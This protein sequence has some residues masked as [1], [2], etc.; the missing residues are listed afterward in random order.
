M[1]KVGKRLP[2]RRQQTIRREM[3]AVRAANTDAARLLIMR[4]LVG[5]LLAAAQVDPATWHSKALQM[6]AAMRRLQLHSTAG[7]AR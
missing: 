4:P 7:I 2:N 6:S 3:A 5:R 1:T